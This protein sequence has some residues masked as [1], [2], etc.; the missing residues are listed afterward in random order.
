MK[1][2]KTITTAA[3]I[4]AVYAVLTIIIAPLSYGAIQ[5][6]FSEALTILP[7][8]TPIAIPGLT[9]GCIIANLF[10][11]Y[12]IYDIVIGS[13]AT[14]FSSITTYY[15]GK[16]LKGK[17]AK[18]LAPLPP[19]IFNA[20][21]VGAIITMYLNPENVL[22]AFSLNALT[23]GVGEFIACYLLGI[24]LLYSLE[25]LNIKSKLK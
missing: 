25:K 17:V 5:L 12:G 6:R 15:I 1:T 3:L 21:F 19:V 20:V 11:G 23:V 9:I 2:T 13:L 22:I 18:F 8:F 7:F 24:P 16:H 4:A 10:G 14:L